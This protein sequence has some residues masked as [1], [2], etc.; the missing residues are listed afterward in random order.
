M[1]TSSSSYVAVF[2]TDNNIKP[3]IPCLFVCFQGSFI[4]ELWKIPMMSETNTV[5]EPEICDVGC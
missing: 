2:H 5:S 1:V 3:K 4:C